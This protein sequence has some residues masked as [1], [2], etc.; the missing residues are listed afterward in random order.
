MT[1]P[2]PSSPSGIEVY[3]LALQE[4][5]AASLGLTKVIPHPVGMGDETEGNW[6]QMLSAHL[7]RRYQVVDKC[8]VVDH[9][10]ECSQEID[11]ALC[12]RQYTTL[13][14]RA[15]TRIFVPAEAVYA[16]FEV[17]QRT[18][19]DYVRYAAEKVQSVRKLERTSAPIVHAGGVI[20]EP[21]AP[22][23]ILGGLLTTTSDWTVLGVPFV[24]A[25]HNQVAEGRLDIGCI[26]K[27]AGWE[28]TYSDQP[29]VSRSVPEHALVFFYLRLLA[30][31]QQHGTVP[32]MDFGAWSGFLRHDSVES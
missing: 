21:S 17:K 30:A 12:D 8:F 29:S 15:G 31:L 3:F 7:P 6:V 2:D 23:P 24:D 16:V 18:N 25:L 26:V 20:K 22:K 11:I 5:L 4:Q 28:A 9:R 14:L 27:V 1:R 32:A 13:I 10:G 19:R